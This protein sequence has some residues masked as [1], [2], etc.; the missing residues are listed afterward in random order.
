MGLLLNAPYRLL[1]SKTP[2]NPTSIKL[3]ACLV[4]L[5]ALALT[6][7]TST[8]P[9]TEAPANQNINLRLLAFN[10]FHGA[11][12]TPNVGIVNG[13][14]GF[15][16]LI[17]AGGIAHLATAI[18]TQSA[19]QAHVR[20]V[21]G[22]DLINASPMISSLF[23]DEPSI[24]ALSM[25]G[26]N[27][28]AVG[29]HEFDRGFDELMRLQNGGCSAAK[30]CFT[31]EG[32]TGAK[33]KCLAANVFKADGAHAFTPYV[34]DKFN[35][36][37]IAFVGAVLKGTPAIVP[38]K[39]I[40]G[41]RFAE[42]AQSANAL[43]PQLKQAGVQT[44]VLLIHEGGNTKGGFNDKSCPQFEG[45]ILRVIDQL[46]AMFKVI[47]SAHTH[48]AY[49]CRVGDRLVTSAS[50]NG[51]LLTTIDLQLSPQGQLLAS[52]ADN[53][54][55]SPNQFAADPT[56]QT[57]VDGF[58][59]RSEPLENRVVGR[60]IGDVTVPGNRAGES[61]MGSLIADGYLF[62]TRMNGAEVA[63]TNTGG[64][65][66]PLISRREDNGI[67]FGEIYSAQ[68]FANTL[69]TFTLTGKQMKDM[70]EAQFPRTLRSDADRVRV[71]QISSTLT[72]S[73]DLSKPYGERVMPDSVK[74]NGTVV[75]ADQKVRVTSSDFLF[76][77]GEGN[78]VFRTGTDVVGG[79]LDVEAL[80]AF[81]AANSPYK[82][83]TPGRIKR[84]DSLGT[85]LQ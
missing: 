6:A 66:A 8:A 44:A 15:G 67:T 82:P 22:G 48:Q 72:Y 2:S 61:P 54:I 47:V 37:P 81:L 58:A 23:L 77:G 35:G 45:A 28:S 57:L 76:N 41:L 80:E 26:L 3:S 51:R 34:I 11:L 32:F 36:V 4:S 1:M 16:K 33:Y 43:V 75:Q 50:S 70:L 52:N 17:R 73:Y 62:A 55:V 29:N 64:L 49:N 71:M 53:M 5:A 39:A 40:E 78:S 19:G 46:D 9:T 59:K 13:D 65:R 18:K 10:D 68:P 74:I 83:A 27:Y 20:V 31:P 38:K 84:L 7:C 21:A 30:G 79:P 42:E 69:M 14:A 12:K 60:V 24:T 25:A 56:L 85:T 63:F